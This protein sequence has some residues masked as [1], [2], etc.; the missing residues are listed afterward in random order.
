MSIVLEYYK[1]LTLYCLQDNRLKCND[2]DNSEKKR[3]RKE[4]NQR[5]SFCDINIR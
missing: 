3:I 4:S 5:S 1:N 2:I